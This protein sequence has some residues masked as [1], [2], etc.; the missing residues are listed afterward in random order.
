ARVDATITYTDTSVKLPSGA[1]GRA[2]VQ[3]A[4]DEPL[5]A[6]RAVELPESFLRSDREKQT[7]RMLIAGLAGLLLVGGIIT[8]ALVVTR[9]RPIVLHDGVLSRG[10]TVGFLGGVA[11][12]AVLDRLQSLPTQLF[13]Y[14]TS[15]PWSRFVGTTLLGFVAVVPIA[16]FVLGVWLT[17]GALRR[18]VGVP[19]APES[20]SPQS[21]VLVSGLG[22]GAVVYAAAHFDSLV[23]T[24]GIPRTPMTMLDLAIPM[25][26][27]V[28]GVPSSALMMAAFVA[29]P[30]LVVGGIA[31]NWKVRAII[32]AA[33]AALIAV[34]VANLA[35][36]GES[37]PA[38][39]AGLVVG[40]ALVALGVRAWGTSS[41]LSWIVAAL[42]FQA[43]NGLRLAVYAPTG[44]ERV[45]GALTLI[46]SAVLVALIR[47]STQRIRTASS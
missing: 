23:P 37:D 33:I 43:L 17:L 25:F 35:P 45:A 8:G 5:V 13:S 10:Q 34:L 39:L 2:W 6:R 28:A 26:G 4:G 16:L 21:D 22:I 30:I 24:T 38:R 36:P 15:E 20:A 11:I 27:G 47:G 14:D 19:M 31:S 29:I 46:V 18:R 42:G 41:A 12:L 7:N 44:Q 3:I 1:V 9:R 40:V 32:G